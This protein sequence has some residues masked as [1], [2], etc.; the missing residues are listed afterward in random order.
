MISRAFRRIPFARGAMKPT[1]AII[2]DYS[3]EVVAHRVAGFPTTVHPF[4]VGSLFQPERAALR[5]ETPPL[6]RAFIAASQTSHQVGH[7]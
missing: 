6:V 5:S 4:F 3:P 1:H 2:G 7:R